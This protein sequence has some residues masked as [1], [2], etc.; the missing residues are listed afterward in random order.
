MKML[1]CLVTICE[2]CGP[3]ICSFR[4]GALANAN[5]KMLISF[6]IQ[7]LPHTELRDRL[8]LIKFANLLKAQQ[9][10]LS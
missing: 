10:Q 7:N 5:G 9:K 6:I 1:T 8:C 4:S 2:V 3:G